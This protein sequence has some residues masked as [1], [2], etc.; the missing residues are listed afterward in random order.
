MLS[1]AK[2]LHYLFENGPMQILRRAQDD[3]RWDFFPSL[4][5][6]DFVS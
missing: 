3:M 6:S 1:A 2:H 5:T 4:R